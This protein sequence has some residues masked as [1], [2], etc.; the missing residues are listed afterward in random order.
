MRQNQSR[1]VAHAV[2]IAIQGG[3]C[4]NPRRRHRRQRR[5][6][7]CVLGPHTWRVRQNGL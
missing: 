2:V 3:N 7:T 4:R 6:G 5:R 1:E